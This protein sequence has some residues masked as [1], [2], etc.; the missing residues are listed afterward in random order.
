M[1]YSLKQLLLFLGIM[2]LGVGC[3]ST[4]SNPLSFSGTHQ[5]SK[6]AKLARESVYAPLDLPRELNKTLGPPYIMEP[7]DIVLVQP[8]KFDS[9]VRLPGDQAIFPDGSISLGEYGRIIIAG[10]TIQAAEKMIQAQIEAK[11]KDAGPMTLRVIS[12]ESKVFYV[13]GEV[14]AP[15][16]F[17]WNGRE[18]VLDGILTAGGL[19]DQASRGKI[20]LSRP[21]QP[22]GCREVLPICYNNIVQ[23]GDTAT[24][25]QLRPGDRI[26]VPS[27]CFSESL[28]WS[29]EEPHC[30]TSQIPCTATAIPCK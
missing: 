7:S 10:N 13:L 29:K 20:I 8:A 21:T 12:R 6:S 25:Y 16:S 9:P 11:T 17:T 27:K 28:P 5:L 26:F 19:T 24:N 15:G 22:D 3:S 2:V 23:L 1:I 4:G 18:T 14:N 30:A